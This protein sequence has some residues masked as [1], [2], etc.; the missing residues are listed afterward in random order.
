DEIAVL[1]RTNGQSRPIEEALRERQISYEVVGGQE[2]FDKRE[3]KDV[4]AYFKVL[5]NPRD[6]VSLLRIVNVPSRGIGDV[7]LERLTAA[8]QQ[9]SRP[10]WDVF[11][12]AAN[13]PDLPRGAPEKV[14]EFCALM[15]RYRAQFSR[16]NLGQV[17]RALLKEIDFASAA[18]ASTASA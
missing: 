18:R 11:R 8:A 9:S 7:T 5:S 13:V 16:G 12:D 1:Y 2:F 17:T 3:V 14:Q 4:I 10:L 15:E 6:E